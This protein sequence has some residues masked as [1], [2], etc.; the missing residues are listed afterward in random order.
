V[1]AIC[2][3]LVKSSEHIATR[4]LEKEALIGMLSLLLQIV[5]RDMMRE[6]L[7]IFVL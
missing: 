2:H 1:Q 3:K 6:D 5:L 4:L 7:S